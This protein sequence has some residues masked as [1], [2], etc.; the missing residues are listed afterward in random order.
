MAEETRYNKS[1]MM[2]AFNEYINKTTNLNI[3]DY[4][5]KS[6][7]EMGEYILT[8]IYNGKVTEF[9][10]FANAILKG[11]LN[12]DPNALD[13]NF[14]KFTVV[15][16]GETLAKF[17]KEKVLM[18]TTLQGNEKISVENFREI[19]MKEA[20]ARIAMK[21]GNVISLDVYPT[22]ASKKTL[23]NMLE[24]YSSFRNQLNNALRKF[25]F[26]LSKDNSNFLVCDK[27]IQAELASKSE[28]KL[29][30][31]VQLLNLYHD[32]FKTYVYQYHKFK[33]IK[34]I[35]AFRKYW[36]VVKKA[37]STIE[38][39]LNE[40]SKN[41]V[42]DSK[43]SVLEGWS[44]QDI[45]HK[46][47]VFFEKTLKQVEINFNAQQEEVSRNACLVEAVKNFK[48]TKETNQY[49]TAFVHRVD[50]FN[51]TFG[52]AQEKACNA[53]YYLFFK[54]SPYVVVNALRDLC[55]RNKDLP[56]DYAKI[57]DQGSNNIK[58]IFAD[59]ARLTEYCLDIAQ[60]LSQ[61]KRSVRK[62]SDGTVLVDLSDE[63]KFNEFIS[64]IESI[65]SQN[66]IPCTK[67]SVKFIADS[68]SSL[69]YGVNQD[70]VKVA[71]NLDYGLPKQRSSGRNKI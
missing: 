27:D 23:R 65:I 6:K 57:L 36:N 5:D 63:E 48:M 24:K 47:D 26:K 69:Q 43:V 54:E 55:S 40:V 31:Q 22:K 51:Q 4:W 33:D 52:S 56:K 66:N 68:Y 71:Q 19:L 34:D 70:A 10:S 20:V 67:Q 58:N 44:F 35:N 49:L 15:K 50:L 14:D 60:E 62:R 3:A 21:Y 2:S 1:H 32:M 12:G 17:L 25:G 38:N 11:Y 28:A 29:D 9:E 39:N 61:Y 7:Y 37:F 64:K 59:N 42:H 18:F 8:Q 13:I 16:L 45:K 30:V 41:F 53:N 46:K